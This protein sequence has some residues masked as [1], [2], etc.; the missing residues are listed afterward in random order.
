M[1]WREPRRVRA[2][3]RT[4]CDF[5]SSSDRTGMILG[6]GGKDTIK[7]GTGVDFADGGPHADTAAGCEYEVNVP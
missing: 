2:Y 1:S 3:G 7:C 5:T 6:R 4:P